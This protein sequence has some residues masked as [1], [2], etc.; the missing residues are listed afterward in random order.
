M[1][2]IKSSSGRIKVNN[3]GKRI[4]ISPLP[5]YDCL[6]FTDIKDFYEYAKEMLELAEK[7]IQVGSTPTF[8]FLIDQD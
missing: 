6:Y 5:G 1:L 4:V 7:A 2:P 3:I 8:P